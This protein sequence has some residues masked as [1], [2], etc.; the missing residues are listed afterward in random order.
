MLGER[1]KRFFNAIKE[2]LWGIEFLPVE[3]ESS[4]AIDCP[5]NVCSLEQQRIPKRVIFYIYIA[6]L[7]FHMLKMLGEI[8]PIV[9]WLDCARRF[10]FWHC[11]GMLEL[12]FNGIC[13]SSNR[14]QRVSQLA[15]SEWRGLQ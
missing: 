13:F 11:V 5:G 6:C 14:N 1:F 3:P 4:M 7:S 12:L 15:L 10:H 8:Y 2:L 9:L